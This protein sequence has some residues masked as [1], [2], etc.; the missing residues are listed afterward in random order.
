MSLLLVNLNTVVAVLCLLMALHLLFQKTSRQLATQLLGACFLILAIHALLLG[1]NLNNGSNLLFA[2]LQ[3]T[4]PVMFGP[5]AYLMFKSAFQINWRLKLASMLHLAPATMVFVL[6]L[7][8]Q[9]SLVADLAIL[10][11]LLAY[12]LVLSHLSWQKKSILQA[13]PEKAAL[14]A[15]EFDKTIYFWLLV[16]STYSWLVFTGDVLIVFEIGAGTSALQ[17]IA[18][19]VTIV[20]KLLIISFTIFLALQKSPLFDWLYEPLSTS[21]EK[22]VE[23]EKLRVFQTIICT[24]EKLTE[25]PTSF[26]QEVSSL[27]AMADRLGVTARIFSN[28][29]NHHYG[30][31]YTKRM[32]RLRVSY[33]EKL[34]IE[35]PQISIMEVMYNSGFQTKSSFNKEFKVLTN[36][37]PSEYRE[38]QMGKSSESE[39][40]KSRTE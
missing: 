16:F 20:F 28:A 2:A 6:M 32:N 30:E 9:G 39:H 38:K 7:S 11:S 19:L 21:I 25:D 12:A 22:N 37:S 35:Q 24:F 23:P 3:P 1:V 36:L 10:L 18:L 4:M 5:L 17:S 40:D 8:E 34:L 13:E 29:I 27:K 14:S 31:S 33:A 26:T 15:Q